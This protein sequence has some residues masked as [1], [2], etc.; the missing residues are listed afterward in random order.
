MIEKLAQWSHKNFSKLPWRQNRSLYTTLVSEIMLQQTTVGTVLQHFDRFIDEYPSFEAVANATE[1]KLTI[2]W[3]GLG[4]Y[5]RARNLKKACIHISQLGKVPQ[6]IH[7]LVKIPGIGDYTAG[8]ILG[9]GMNLPYLAIDGNLE[10][11]IARIYGL[12]MESGTKLKK[13]II[14]LFDRGEICQDIHNVG[15]RAF[16]EALMDLGRNYCKSNRVS[17]ELC[18]LKSKCQAFKDGNQ[19]SIPVKLKESIKSLNLTLLRV[20]VEEDN[21]I[22][23]YQKKSNQWLSGQWEIPT[24]VLESEDEKLVQYPWTEKRV[25][26]EYLP[27]FKSLITKYRIDNKV[28]IASKEELKEL[29]LELPEG[30]WLPLDKSRQNFSTA[31]IKAFEI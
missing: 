3:K 27:A 17:C 26:Y 11:V 19:L 20:L 23:V 14:E 18:P 6:S 25:E 10:R 30:K 22:Y 24:F 12:N 29:G 15:G 9:I 7:E 5:R 13:H 21:K 16:N 8:A 1:E 28:L 4:Y 2:S 31:T